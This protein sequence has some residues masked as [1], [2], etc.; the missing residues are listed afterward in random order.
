MNQQELMNYLDELIFTQTGKHLDSLQLSILKGVLK[1]QKYADIAQEYNCSNGHAKDKAYELWQILSDAL[2]EDIN[3]ANFKANI[4]RL[5]FTN[6]QHQIIGNPIQIGKINL[7]GE[8]VEKEENELKNNQENIE[9]KTKLN[10]IPQLIK[11]GLTDE[12]IAS[13]LNLSLE[14]VTKAIS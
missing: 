2:D 3:K 1:G 10:I 8:S 6:T 7:C 12:Q 13:G 14:E 4:E 5:G 11:L 9:L